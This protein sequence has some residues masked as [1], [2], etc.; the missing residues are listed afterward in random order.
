MDTHFDSVDTVRIDKL[1]CYLRFTKTRS[2]AH[3]WVQKGHI[4]VDGLRVE[5][6]HFMVHAGQTLT[7]PMRDSVLVIRIDV[8]PHRRGAPAEARSCYSVID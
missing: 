5:K 2:A 6:P 3:I 8:L 7:L 4:R 1:L